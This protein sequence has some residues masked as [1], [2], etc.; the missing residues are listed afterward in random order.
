MRLLVVGASGLVGGHLFS[1]ASAA[2]VPARGTSRRALPG[3]ATCELS[4]EATLRALVD[5]FQPTAVA[6]AA[7]FT[8]ADGC[9]A[10]P[11]R[12]RR[13]NLEQPLALAGLCARLGV[14]FAYFSSSYVFDGRDGDYDESCRPNP[15]NVYGRHKAEAEL[16]IA[17]ATGGEALILRLIHVWGVESRGKNFVYQVSRANAE[18]AEFPVSSVHL[19][20]P[21][22][23]GDVATWTL[24]L[25]G[26]A[27]SGVWHLAGD[28]PRL[29]RLDW[30][31]EILRG[32]ERMGRPRRIRLVPRAA[33]PAETPRPLSAGL[34]T[35]KAQR[36]LPLVCRAPDDLPA[37]LGE[38]PSR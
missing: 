19:G 13:E 1:A 29:S 24:G 26:A 35:L 7:G 9:Q 5:D 22:W 11:G 38:P 36:F 31:G 21:T 10:D 20:N 25:L 14:R 32:L 27:S 6:C 30:A 4:D 17:E 23:A 16:R 2:R 8:W 33:P 37:E 3:L 12:S 18:G 28:S 34:R 15:L